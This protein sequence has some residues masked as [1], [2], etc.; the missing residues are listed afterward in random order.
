MANSRDV[1]RPEPRENSWYIELLGGRESA[2][3]LMKVSVA[4]TVFGE[5]RVVEKRLFSVLALCWMRLKVVI[6]S[7]L[8]SWRNASHQGREK[9]FLGS[10]AMESSTESN[11]VKQQ[12]EHFVKSKRG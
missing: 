1:L 4:L 5:L 6:D 11:V 7:M 8:G 10:L 9:S 3:R 2:E 12:D